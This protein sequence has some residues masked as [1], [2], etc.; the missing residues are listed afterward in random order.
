MYIHKT[1]Q[2]NR[3]THKKNTPYTYYIQ[4][5]HTHTSFCILF[6]TQTDIYCDMYKTMK[7]HIITGANSLYHIYD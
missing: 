6:H 2:V 4:H 7:R 1:R 5:P 3:Q